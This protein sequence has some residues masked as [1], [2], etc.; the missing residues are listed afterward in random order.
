MESLKTL[1]SPWTGRKVIEELKAV[2]D[3]TTMEVPTA[4]EATI[5]P[6]NMVGLK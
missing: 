5:S 4:V 2:K 6:S 3:N 1:K